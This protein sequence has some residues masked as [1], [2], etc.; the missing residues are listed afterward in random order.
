MKNII[1]LVL[2]VSSLNNLYGAGVEVVAVKNRRIIEEGLTE[3]T[4]IDWFSNRLPQTKLGEYFFP[5]PDEYYRQDCAQVKESSEAAGTF[6]QKL[7]FLFV[8]KACVNEGTGKRLVMI[9][10]EVKQGAVEIQNLRRIYDVYQEFNNINGESALISPALNFFQY[11]GND[12][13]VRYF[14]LIKAARGKSLSEYLS[15]GNMTE[16]TDAFFQSG[17]ALSKFH[18]RFLDWSTEPQPESVGKFTDFY[19]TII[20][21]DAHLQNIFYNKE[22]SK[23]YLIDVETMAYSL[24]NKYS[25]T[26]DLERIYNLPIYV[27][28]IFDG[29]S[30][31]QKN[32]ECTSV[33]QAYAAFFAGYVQAFPYDKQVTL[34]NFIKVFLT[35]HKKIIEFPFDKENILRRTHDALQLSKDPQSVELLNQSLQNSFDALLSSQPTKK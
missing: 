12:G 15:S 20:H 11:T 17:R 30:K 32:I 21:G 4:L 13:L 23:T 25:I 6:T 26:I 5:L 9:I 1:F 28:G 2:I 16:I 31:K 27:W 8:N 22:T 3:K 18:Q 24:D 14:T 34:Y 29:C 10:K 33:G 19:K 7:F 35:A